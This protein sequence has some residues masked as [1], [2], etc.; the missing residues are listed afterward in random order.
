MKV[1]SVKQPWA[2]AIFHG[3]DIEN[4]DWPTT[5]RGQLGIHASKGLSKWEY[6][7]D[8]EFIK[9]I[10]GVIVPAYED[11]TFGA[12]LGT[13]TLA[14]CVKLSSSPWFQGKY[15]FVLEDPKPWNIPHL[16]RGALGFW[17]FDERE[18]FA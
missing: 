17:H 10:N 18:L 2:W 12:I 14:D 5:Y 6:A 13:V 9:R 15:G 16:A 3:K 7:D 1:L 11:L 4:R 8:A